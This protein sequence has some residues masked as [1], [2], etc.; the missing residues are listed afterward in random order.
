[1]DAFDMFSTQTETYRTSLWLWQSTQGVVAPGDLH[2][3]R[4][5]AQAAMETFSELTLE[6]KVETI[7]DGTTIYAERTYEENRNL[8]VVTRVENGDVVSH[9][10]VPDGWVHKWHP[11]RR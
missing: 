9:A 5:D 10:S 11:N 7:D 2:E 8:A 1:M 3:S 6:W 4:E